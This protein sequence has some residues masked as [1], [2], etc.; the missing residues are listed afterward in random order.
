MV[1]CTEIPW[2][3]LFVG[4][5]WGFFVAGVIF[6][7]RDVL[8]ESAAERRRMG[9]NGG[10]PWRYRPG[11]NPMPTY[12]RPLPPPNPPCVSEKA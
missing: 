3:Y 4:Y 7:K 8:R 10:V 1:E 5:T 2:F 9:L 12:Q 11:S 6:R